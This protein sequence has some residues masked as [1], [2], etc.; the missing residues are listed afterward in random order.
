MKELYITHSINQFGELEDVIDQFGAGGYGFY[1]HLLERIAKSDGALP[2]QKL[3]RVA[4]EVGLEKGTALECTSLLEAMGLVRKELRQTPQ[5]EAECLVSDS[6]TGD[7]DH[8]RQLSEAGR[9]AITARWAKYKAG[10]SGESST[11]I[12]PYSNR[13][14]NGH[15]TVILNTNTD[16]DT[17]NSILDIIVKFIEDFLTSLFKKIVNLIS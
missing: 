8:A 15:T 4:S 5:G 6:I 11:V 17:N 10:N 16:T 13:S 3:L 1:W 2:M 9:K 12:R 14:T 7:I